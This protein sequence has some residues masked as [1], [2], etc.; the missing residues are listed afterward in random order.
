MDRQCHIIILKE[1]NIAFVKQIKYFC[2]MF[3][4][5]KFHVRK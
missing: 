3:G 4:G 2:V 1:L 5:K